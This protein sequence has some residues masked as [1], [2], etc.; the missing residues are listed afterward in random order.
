MT[1][2]GSDPSKSEP[3]NLPW[4]EHWVIHKIQ[5]RQWIWLAILLFLLLGTTYS[6]VTPVFEASDELWHYPFVWHLA[7]GGELPVQDP[8][9]HGPW[10]QEGSQ[11]PLYYGLGALLTAWVDTDDI[12][13]V[14]R[15]NPHADIGIVTADGNVNMMVHT[16][17][18]RFPYRGTVLAVHLVRLF[19]VLLGAGTVW[20]IFHI[21]LSVLPGRYDVA[22]AASLLAATNAM[23][24]FISGSVNNDNLIVF[25]CSAVILLLLRE[26]ESPRSFRRL[27][28]IGALIGLAALSKASGLALLPLSILVLFVAACQRRDIR[29]EKRVMWF[30]GAVAWVLL[31][32]LLI[33]GWW[34]WRNW[35]LYRDPL[36][37]NVFVAIVGAR[38]PKPTWLQLLREVPGFL[39]AYWG[40]FGGMN[41]AMPSW[42]YLILNM[43][44]GMG[45]LGAVVGLVRWSKG[46]PK[47]ASRWAQWATLLVWLFGVIAAL[48]HWTRLTPASQGRLIFPA[49]STISILIA[50][51]L[52]RWVPRRYHWVPLSAIC[53][54]QL[55]IA[56]WVPCGVILPAYSP[57]APLTADEIRSIPVHIDADFGDRIRLLGY[58]L[59]PEIVSPGGIVHL[60]LYWQGLTLM[61]TDYSVFVHLLGDNDLIFGQRDRYPGQGNLPTSQWRL[62]EVIADRF[63]L[64]VSET[65]LTPD[66]IQVEVGLYDWSTGQRLSVKEATDE[67]LRDYV[68]FGHIRLVPREREGIPNPVYFDLGG[69][70][71]LIGYDLDRTA[72]RPGEAF[73]LT[74][75]WRCL[76]EMDENYS[77][78]T[79]VLGD[80]DR[81]W[82]QKDA[83]PRGGD[84]PTAAWRKGQ[85]VEDPYELVVHSDTPP[86]I[87]E[88]EVGMYRG[89]ERLPVTDRNGQVRGTRIVLGKVRIV[90]Q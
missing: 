32:V 54:F 74:L 26:L 64:R 85:I 22:L 51:G 57:P 29:W 73:H 63:E 53:G 43:W 40:V 25:L 87:Y 77:V 56:L 79:H 13:I 10:R 52:T 71:A 76:R 15:R 11:P 80:A 24:L 8:A 9:H 14:M 6:V 37:L 70:I 47:R 83:W 65:A 67:P 78:F 49:I 82:A 21:A 45:L 12:S 20:C 72:A 60:T 42:V 16:P 46:K 68:R 69:K 2:S 44:A 86:G 58:D 75:Y 23:F 7:R 41:V 17:R 4:S 31:L 81:I 84:A 5:P 50:W 27:T 90:K 35:R 33:A 3:S 66:E 18:E 28:A 19:S 59:E 88:L 55:I 36:G 62:G 30:V 48:V 34:Y 61:E 1:I 38:Y 39:R 89:D